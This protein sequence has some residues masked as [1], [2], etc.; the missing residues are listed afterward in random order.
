LGFQSGYTNSHYLSYSTQAI[1]SI[2][3]YGISIKVQILFI[4]N[5]DINSGIYVRLGSAN[6]NPAYINGNAGNSNSSTFANLTG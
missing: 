4:D 2:N 1:N 3:Y 6:N 5:W